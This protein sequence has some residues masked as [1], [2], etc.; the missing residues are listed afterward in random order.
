MLS[1]LVLLKPPVT[2]SQEQE[3]KICTPCSSK[4]RAAVAAI[5]ANSQS[6]LRIRRYF[7]SL[8]TQQVLFYS[9]H[10]PNR[11]IISFTKYCYI[12]ILISEHSS[13]KMNTFIH[14]CC[15]CKPP[16]HSL[17][18]QITIERRK[19]IKIFICFGLP[20]QLPEIYLRKESDS[21]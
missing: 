16:N 5:T 20:V 10:N 11:F 6:L 7:F 12:E 9:W 21:V 18:R 4:N 14:Y 3:V 15:L 1:N 17:Q 13:D 8:Q 19:F 2:Q